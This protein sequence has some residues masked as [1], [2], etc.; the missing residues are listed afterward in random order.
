MNHKKI[1]FFVLTLLAG[2]Y[3]FWPANDFQL[4][5]AQG[6][7][8]RDLYSFKKTFEGAVPHRDFSTSNG[9]LMLYYYSFFYKIFGVSIQSTILG[10]NILVILA[11]ILIYFCGLILVSAPFAFLCALWYWTSRTGEF[12]YTYN[13]IGAIALVLTMV[14]FILK[15]LRNSNDSAIYQGAFFSF[16][17]CLIRPNIGISSLAVFLLSA[18]IFDIVKQKPFLLRSIMR[19]GFVSFVIFL[20]VFLVYS[21]IFF[22]LPKH[23]IFD[24]LSY[25][26]SLKSYKSSSST[27]FQAIVMLYEQILNGFSISW[28]RLF[29]NSA[30]VFCL[31]KSLQALKNGPFSREEKQ[32]FLLSCMVLVFFLISSLHEFLLSAIPFRSH[33]TISL[34]PLIVIFIFYQG[35]R[36]LSKFIRSLLWVTLFIVCFLGITNYR[37]FV[38]ASKK[39]QNML[40]VGANKVYL[41]SNQ[42]EWIQTVTD[43]NRFI[44]KNVPRGEKIIAIPSDSIYYFL[45]G[46]DRAVRES[47]FH[48]FNGQREQNV[49]NDLER[50]KINFIILSNRALRPTEAQ[51]MGIMGVDYGLALLAYIE[52]NFNE[53]A[54]F[55]PWE[56]PAGWVTNHA[57]KI[58]KRKNL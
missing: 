50:T 51:M 15:Y 16:L 13:H 46:H 24:D 3:I 9:P 2:I 38:V 48:G 44:V 4:Y 35:V 17:L 12:F 32:N 57:V 22:H 36:D 45:S 40:Q 56:K 55:G 10:Y 29:L 7:H 1:I 6:D 20:A 53:M 5:L 25:F 34:T 18:M 43:A 37:N 52:R 8:G 47:D 14:Y 21:A 30:F 23:F 26:N 19:Y 39:P 11:G 31:L 27:S 54:V 33:W 42:K 28:P 58:F 49:I 41:S